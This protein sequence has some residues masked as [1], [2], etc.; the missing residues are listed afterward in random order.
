M[1][2]IQNKKGKKSDREGK[3]GKIG[4]R[5][6]KKAEEG[7]MSEKLYLLSKIYG[8]RA[9]GF[10]RSNRKNSYT[11]RELYI[12]TRNWGFRQ[13]SRCRGSLLL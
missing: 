1:R 2:K 11:Q 13:T 12:G 3:E 5:K 9:V 10:R 4:E 6:E 8:D 7:K